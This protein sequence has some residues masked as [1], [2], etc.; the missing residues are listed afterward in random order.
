MKTIFE[1]Q[2]ALDEV[3]GDIFDLQMAHPERAE[4]AKKPKRVATIPMLK[5]QIG[6]ADTWLTKATDSINEA[7]HYLEN[8][9][10][11]VEPN[12]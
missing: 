11:I 12:L 5:K 6:D 1:L 10:E 4:I 9:E 7:I 2:K 8:Y 3:K